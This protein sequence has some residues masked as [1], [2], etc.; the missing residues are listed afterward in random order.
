PLRRELLALVP[1]GVRP[2][3]ARARHGETVSG[4]GASLDNDPCVARLARLPWR[5]A[6]CRSA[7]RSDRRRIARAQ[8]PRLPRHRAP[9]RLALAL[10]LD[11]V[12]I[13]VGDVDREGEEQRA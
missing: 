7:W 9:R 12:A 10:L 8:L 5:H 3:T 1:V 13:L 11:L 4:V 2:P 6:G